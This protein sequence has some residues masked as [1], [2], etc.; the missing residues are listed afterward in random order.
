[1]FHIALGKLDSELLSPFTTG[2][3]PP[4]FNSQCFLMFFGTHMNSSAHVYFQKN[5]NMWKPCGH[6]VE[7]SFK[8][9]FNPQLLFHMCVDLVAEISQASSIR[10]PGQLR[11]VAITGFIR[12]FTQAADIVPTGHGHAA[13]QRDSL[14]GCSGQPAGLRPKSWTKSTGKCWFLTW[15]GWRCLSNSVEFPKLG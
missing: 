5:V 8:P 9:S 1:M 6:H 15:F 12:T 2:S 11:R 14:D 13:V 3:N 4:W 7:T 10:H